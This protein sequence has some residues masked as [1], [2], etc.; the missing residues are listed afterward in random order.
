MLYLLNFLYAIYARFGMFFPHPKFLLA[1]RC[2]YFTSVCVN[3]WDIC[4]SYLRFIFALMHS[5]V[6]AD[7]LL[8]I[9]FYRYFLTPLTLL[10]HLYTTQFSNKHDILTV[11]RH[12]EQPGWLC[13][14]L[15]RKNKLC[16]SNRDDE[17]KTTSS[18]ET[19]RLVWMLFVAMACITTISTLNCLFKSFWIILGN[20]GKDSQ[21][22]K[23]EV[24]SILWP[25]C[26]M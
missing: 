4:G 19:L 18:H 3:A 13:A 17:I 5:Y 2:A 9:G 22:I 14:S 11:S 24:H 21:G 25:W 10:K 20:R 8:P 15:W 16:E 12:S 23:I 6:H 7:S 1:P 26:Y